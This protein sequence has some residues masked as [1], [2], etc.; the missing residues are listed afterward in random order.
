MRRVAV[1]LAALLALPGAAFAAFP[2]D[3]PNDPLYDASPLP[4]ATNEQWDMSSDRGISADRA[5]KLS[6]G[7]GIVIADIDVGVQLD[8]PDLQGQ[9]APGGHDF[10]GNDADPTSETRNAHGTNVAG[11][12][13][14]KAD[15]GIDI[16]GTGP[17]ARILP[18][19]TSDNILHSGARLAEALVYAADHGARVASM[20]LGADSFNGAMRHAVR[21]AHRRG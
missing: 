7:E 17:G 3:P 2:R 10:Y 14:A 16:A 8:H 11:V 4:G 5:W 18:L 19:R 6:T 20:S 1:V 13:A 15:N 21:Y 12:L 9:W